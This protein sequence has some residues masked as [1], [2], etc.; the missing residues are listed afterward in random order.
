MQTERK[1]KCKHK[2]ERT[3]KDRN[4]LHPIALLLV[5]ALPLFTCSPVLALPL[6]KE[7]RKKNANTSQ[8]D[9]S[10]SRPLG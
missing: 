10:I 5:F 6:H 8:K 9:K 4:F 3:P 2:R 1:G 7:T